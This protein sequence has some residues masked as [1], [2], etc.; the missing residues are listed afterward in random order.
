VTA[1]NGK[2]F[3][4]AAA[5]VWLLIFLI[6]DGDVVRRPMSHTTTPTYRLASGQWWSGLDPY[7]YNSHSG[8]LYFPQ[9]AILFT[10]FTW[11]PYLL[12]EILWRAVVFG[13]FAYAL[14]R[15]ARFFVDRDGQVGAKTFLA[16]SLLAVPSSMASLRNAQFD[17]PLAA[18]VV[19]ATAEIAEA[20]WTR[21]TIWLCLALALK[22]LAVVPFLLF[23]ALYLR[24]LIP[25]LALGILVTLLVPFLN[26]NPAFVAHEYFRCAQTLMWAAQPH[27][28]KFSDLPA[29]LDRVRITLPDQ[30]WT[31][32]RVLFA[33]LFL[34]LGAMAVRRLIRLEA[35]WAIGALSTT[36]LM[37]FNPRTETCSY[38]F[39]APF[40]AALS[41]IYL[42]QKGRVWLGF[43]LCFAALSFAC[44]A[45]PV[46]HPLTDRWLKPLVALLFLPVVI[47]FIFGRRTDV[48]AP[49]D[50]MPVFRNV[51]GSSTEAA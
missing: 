11:G 32:L 4:L 29:L 25:R 15:L 39:L 7:T 38:V 12:G 5:G 10:P 31:A 14:W 36:Y 43:A 35:A 21:A 26:P 16:L 23:A 1:P 44:D 6:I 27:E 41:L 51:C 34:G 3:R 33:L 2:R 18:L 49:H 50:P 19:L 46:I 42:R 20:R 48:H 47:E 13:L 9:A 28:P 40:V 45:I 24:P 8:F 30:V 22:P 17:L 37:L